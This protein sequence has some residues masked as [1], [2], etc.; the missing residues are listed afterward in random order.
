MG[1]LQEKMAKIKVL[2]ICSRNAGRSQMAEGYLNARYGDR[3]DARSAG[4]HT[5]SVNPFTIRVMAEIGI[6]TGTQYSKN[7]EEF[8]DETFDVIVILT[9]T[10]GHQDMLPEAKTCIHRYFTDPG[11]FYGNEDQILAG[12]RDVRDEITGWIDIY[13]G[14]PQDID[15]AVHTCGDPPPPV[16]PR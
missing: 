3:Y 4:I 1:G 16:L 10:A 13:F 14:P 8:N 6:N 2:F 5:G 9:D 12:F 11:S 7:C 15:P